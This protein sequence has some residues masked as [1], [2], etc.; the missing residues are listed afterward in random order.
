MNVTH[1]G[2]NTPP[3]VLNELDVEVGPE[4]LINPPEAS[5]E[6]S[7]FHVFKVSTLDTD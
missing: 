5:R 4:K 1:D 3:K 6:Y 2:V 7:S